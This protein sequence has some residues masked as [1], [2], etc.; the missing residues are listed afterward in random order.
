MRIHSLRNYV[1]LL[2]ILTLLIETV[3]ALAAAAQQ[4][5]ARRDTP[6]W[7]WLLLLL[8]AALLVWWLWDSPR[9]KAAHRQS[10]AAQ[11][12][13]PESL[14]EAT[15]QAA[16]TASRVGAAAADT[17]S[18]QPSVSAAAVEPPV[19]APIAEKSLAT[20][21]RAQSAQKRGDDLTVVEGIGPKI[22]AVLQRA[23]I[24]SYAALAA[25]P[26]D[27]LRKLLADNN[28][29]LAD[30]S[31]WPEQAVLAATDP[32]KLAEFQASLKGGRRR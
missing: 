23:G 28:L 25:T 11:P 20:P 5:V 14:G 13:V 18:V 26:V 9:Q 10:V 2:A 32:G 12:K 3:P 17:R 15:A 21:K 19:A 31:T 30:P 1:P 6:L 16:V 29:R 7:I 24:D 8:A 4:E 27:D 22:S